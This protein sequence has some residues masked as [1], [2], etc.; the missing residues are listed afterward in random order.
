MAVIPFKAK[1]QV[2]ARVQ[3]KPGLMDVPHPWRVHLTHPPEARIERDPETGEV[4]PSSFARGVAKRK[5]E[6][7]CRPACG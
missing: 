4:L 3:D 7:A 5:A 1:V 6:E 2:A